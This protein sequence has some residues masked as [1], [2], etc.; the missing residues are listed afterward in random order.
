MNI[1]APQ[2]NWPKRIEDLIAR[3]PSIPLK[4]MGFP[5]DWENFPIWKN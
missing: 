5:E 1:I 3:F 2:S 4:L